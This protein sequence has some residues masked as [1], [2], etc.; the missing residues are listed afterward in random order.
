MFVD[1]NTNGAYDKIKFEIKIATPLAS[2]DAPRAKDRVEKA[3]ASYSFDA[4][5]F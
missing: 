1:N 4:I 3:R 5:S 2:K